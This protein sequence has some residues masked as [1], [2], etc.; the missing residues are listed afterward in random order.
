MIAQVPVVD[1]YKLEKQITLFKGLIEENEE[2]D[3]VSH[4][5]KIVPEFI[6]QSSRFEVL[7]RLN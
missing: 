6:S 7:D 5:K 2:N 1:Y 3:L 4:L